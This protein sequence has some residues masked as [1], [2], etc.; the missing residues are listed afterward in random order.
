MIIDVSSDNVTQPTGEMWEAMSQAEVLGF[1]VPEDR[2]T[3]HLEAHAAKITGKEAALLLPT[4]TQANLVAI[5]CQSEPYQEVIVGPDSHIYEQELGGAGAIAGV[6]V[7]TWGSAGIPSAS[8]LQDLVHPSYRFPTIA[9]PKPAL[10]CLENPHNA[11]GGTIISGEKMR[12]FSGIIRSMVP[13]IHLDGARIFNAAASMQ[14]SVREL[15]QGADSV[16]FSLDK[17]L[18]APFGAMLC[19]SAEMVRRARKMRRML[20]GYTRKIGIYAAAGVVALEKMRARVG[21]DNTRATSL[22]ARLNALEGL[23]VDPFPIPTNLI[24]VNLS[25]LGV[26][27]ENFVDRL[28]IV[29]GIASHIYGRDVVRFAVHRHIG[30][31][32]ENYIVS[33]VEALINS[34]ESESSTRV[35]N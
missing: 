11:S 17:C 21:E 20:G 9:S 18:S 32:E 19:G 6:M 10:V 7:K 29:Y 34:L 8:V 13:R 16:M 5:L 33:A 25:A 24:M 35:G 27:P 14:T 23:V 28:K 22:G 30:L 4:G 2:I 12:E 31:D 3:A 1:G 15:V 26:E